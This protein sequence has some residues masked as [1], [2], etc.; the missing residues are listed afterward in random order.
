[1]PSA[2]LLPEDKTV[3]RAAIGHDCQIYTATIARLYYSTAV[4][5]AHSV[6]NRDWN[7]ALTGAIAFMKD[8]RRMNTFFFRMVDLNTGKVVWEQELY[9]DFS[10]PANQNCYRQDRAWFHSFGGDDMMY[11]LSFADDN[12]GIS[13]YSKV[14]NRDNLKLNSRPSGGSSVGSR[15][16]SG[17]GIGPQSGGIVS[18]GAGAVGGVGSSAKKGKKSGGGG[19]RIDKSQIGQPS[20]FRHLTHVGYSAEGGFNMVNVPPEWNKVFEKAGITE[21][22][23]KDQSTAKFIFDFMSNYKESGGGGGG[24]SSAAVPPGPPQIQRVD[25]PQTTERVDSRR[26]APGLPPV[27]P[28]VPQSQQVQTAVRVPPPVPN[29]QVPPVP[30]RAQP[31]VSAPQTTAPPPPMPSRSVSQP[32][33]SKQPQEQSYA[34]PQ[35]GVPSAPA[36]PPMPPLSPPANNI[37]PVAKAPKASIPSSDAGDGRNALLDAIRSG[38]KSVLKPAAEREANQKTSNEDLA[39]SGAGGGDVASAL[40]M[41]LMSRQAAMGGSVQDEDSGSEDE[42]DDW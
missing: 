25:E 32:P 5:T 42:D 11:G 37:S 28:P 13:F 19:G 9:R 15:Q 31:Q 20:N 36:P 41:A 22:Q 2:T 29:R 21:E 40:K 14:M 4:A 3:I 16:N 26:A 6:S 35:Q 30:G 18:S 12:E 38:G 10:S 17:V 1:M 39:A 33:V 8:T 27:K 34:A 7:Y 24:S 23:L